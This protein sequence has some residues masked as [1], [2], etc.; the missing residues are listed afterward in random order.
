M[1]KTRNTRSQT[2]WQGSGLVK[3]S[4]TR[5]TEEGLKPPFIGIEADFKSVTLENL[6]TTTNRKIDK[7]MGNV[8]EGL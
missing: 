5:E 4:R 1:N 2:S 7:S 3:D 8:H 6:A